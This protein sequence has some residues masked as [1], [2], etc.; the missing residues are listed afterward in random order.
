MVLWIVI[1]TSKFP[2]FKIV[3]PVLS[4]GSIG[5]Y[6]GGYPPNYTYGNFA[7]DCEGDFIVDDCG[8]CGGNNYFVWIDING[9]LDEKDRTILIKAAKHCPVSK[10]IHPDIDEKIT[11]NFLKG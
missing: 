1:S 10:S 7:C 6:G 11:F 3:Y 9:E 4:F 5:F 2:V 8:V